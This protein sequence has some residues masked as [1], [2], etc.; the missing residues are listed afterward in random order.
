MRKVNPDAGLTVNTFGR[1]TTDTQIREG[2]A[3]YAEERQQAIADLLT[4]RGRLSVNELADRFTVTTETVRR[5]LTTLERAGIVRRVHGGAIPAASLSVLEIAVNERD[6]AQSD[7]KDRVAVAA[8]DLLPPTGGSVLL[9]AGTTTA[10]LAGLLPIDATFT[11]FTNAVPIAGRL[12]GRPNVDLHVLPGRVRRTTQAAVGEETVEA[13][14]RLRTD[15]AFVGTNGLSVAHGLSTP[16][17][18]EAA[19]K[20]AMLRSAQRVV[21]LADSS[22]IG[23]ESTVRFGDLEQVDV[24]VTDEGLSADD[25]ATLTAHDIEVVVA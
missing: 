15:V 18:S 5:D 9:D 24:L 13:I 25:R 3:V 17:A 12:A 10:R 14:R 22:K 1:K 23:H 20:S 4:Q 6:L 19:A 2:A 16:D 8:L 21:V 11:I 7:Q